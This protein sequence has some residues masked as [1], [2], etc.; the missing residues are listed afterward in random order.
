MK[1]APLPARQG[2]ALLRSFIENASVP[3]FLVTFEGTIAYANRAGTELLGDRAGD[4]IGSDFRTRL[5]P[6]DAG[7]ARG[8]AEALIAGKISSFQSERRYLRS[9]GEPGWVLTSVSI[10]S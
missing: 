9:T 5:H 1:K 4:L 7:V 10:L 3:S 6:D 8:Q 2:G